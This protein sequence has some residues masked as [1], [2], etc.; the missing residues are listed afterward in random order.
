M[1]PLIGNVSVQQLAPNTFVVLNFNPKQSFWD[2]HAGIIGTDAGVI[3]FD[4]GFNLQCAE[5]LWNVAEEHFAVSGKKQNFL[6][7]SHHHYDHTFG[8]EFF[9]KRNVTIVASQHMKGYVDGDEGRYT[10]AVLEE[11]KPLGAQPTMF[12]GVKLSIPHI[13]LQKDL[14][15]RLGNYRFEI[16]LTPGHTDDSLC[17]YDP[18]TGILMT[19]DSLFVQPSS[20]TIPMADVDKEIHVE[21]LQKLQQLDCK[22]IF[23]GHGPVL[24][25]PRDVLAALVR[26]YQRSNKA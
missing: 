9:R 17:L 25:Q 26:R 4:S 23:A 5:Y 14:S 1:R 12:T 24:T 10:R 20:P 16:L 18:Q 13:L 22:T 8:M 6:V 19:G 11:R 3:F 15:Y 21:S 2:T 7:L